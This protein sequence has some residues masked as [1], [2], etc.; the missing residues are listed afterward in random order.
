M[1]K[2]GRLLALVLALSFPAPFTLAQDTAPAAQAPSEQPIDYAAW[3]AVAARAETALEA[4]R[5]SDRALLGLRDE[6]STW[7]ERLGEAASQNDDRINTLKTQ[8]ATLGPA[9]EEGQVEPAVLTQRRNELTQQL[10]EAEAPQKA[11][12]EAHSRADALIGQ[13][14][15]TLRG[16]QASA[17]F[18]LGPTPLNPTEWPGAISDLFG[19]FKLA[20]GEVTSSWGSEAQQ[21]ELQRDLP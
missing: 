14:D 10:A 7:R 17:L 4:G 1:I 18:T 9:P 3:E 12:D 2:L 8:I 11:A 5:V 13:I 19:T 15:T 16:R 20:W 6:L 21:T